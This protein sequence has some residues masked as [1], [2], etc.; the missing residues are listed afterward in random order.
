LEEELKKD[1][2]VSKVVA[3]PKAY[4]PL[5]KCEINGVK[6]DFVMTRISSINPEDV[7]EHQVL[8]DKLLTGMSEH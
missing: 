7:D 4:V 2:S 3:I 1:S 5:V 8:N 6:V